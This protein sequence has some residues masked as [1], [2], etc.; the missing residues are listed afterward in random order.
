MKLIKV[1]KQNIQPESVL[2]M[3]STESTVNQKTLQNEFPDVF[4]GD[5]KLEGKLHLDIDKTVTPV[6]L[7]TRKVPVAIK[8]KVKEHIDNL[9]QRGVLTPVDVPTDWI[10]SVVIVTKQ[11]G[12]IRL[13]IDPKPLNSALKRNHYPSPLIDDLLS[14]L[15]NVELFSVAGAI[16]G[17][18]HLELDEE[19]SFLTTFGTPWGR[20][21]WIRM[22]FGISPAP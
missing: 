8:E 20:Y 12:D 10:S 2:K 13:C 14:D 4:K 22:P 5:G 15:E 21:R 6:K 7:T 18:W 9:Y 19:S 17:L 1:N 3:E 11:S 16:N